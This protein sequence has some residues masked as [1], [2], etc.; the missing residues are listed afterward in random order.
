MSI[1][2]RKQKKGVRYLAQ[3]I[4]NRKC[5][6]SKTFSTK[7]EAEAWKVE[8]K[9][10]LSQPKKAKKNE[11]YNMSFNSLLDMFIKERLPQLS[12]STQH[13]YLS[14]TRYFRKSPIA[15]VRMNKFSAQDVDLWLN[16][17]RKHPFGKSKIRK[18]FIRDL[19]FLS[20]ILLW[21][22]NYINADFNFPIV[23]RHREKCF[24]K[25]L[26][27]RRPDYFIKPN[28]IKIWLD[29]LEKTE[30]PVYKRLALF[31]LLTGARVGEACGLKW[32]EVDF[33]QKFARIV[34]VAS[35]RGH[36]E[37]QLV[38][39]AKTDNSIRILPLPN[40]LINMLRDMKK[41]ASLK[42]EMVFCDSE[43]KL[44]KDTRIRKV[45]NRCFKRVNLPWSGTHILRH[46]FATLALMATR[47]LSAVQASLGH[48]DQKITQG[49]AKAIAVLESRTSEKTAE[50]IGLKKRSQLIK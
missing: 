48:T 31:M 32:S 13:G 35:W 46:T 15:N 20:T 28:E 22:K 44:L 38:E 8:E 19:K 18:T 40:I 7:S 24:F 9:K 12:P 43:G 27:I 25:P 16:Y 2:K 10:R 14:M 49:Y 11:L 30:N 4:I 17:I 34:R 39:S 3:V 33:E 36:K 47:D 1:I 42:S 41:D 21:F 5:V 29:E 23:K 6:S 37:P 26:E 45:F 50:F